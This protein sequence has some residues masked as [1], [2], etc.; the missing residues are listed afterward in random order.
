MTDQAG[1]TEMTYKSLDSQTT[2]GGRL[3]VV[4]YGILA[5][6]SDARTAEKLFFLRESGMKLKSVKITLNKGRARL[7][8]GAL[9]H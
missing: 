7:E 1:R 5:G 2:R 8:P 4:E 3:E 6:S 9:Y